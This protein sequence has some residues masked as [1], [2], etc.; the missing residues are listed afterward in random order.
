MQNVFELWG[1]KLKR[2]LFF[3]FYDK[4]GIVDTYI[5]YLL[6]DFSKSVDKIVIIING[7]CNAEGRKLLEKYSSDIF[8]RE[9]K[10]Y[11]AGAY[12]AAIFEYFGLERM[13]LYDEVIFMN[14]TFFGPFYPSQIIFN[15]M[16]KRD[17]DFW[18]ITRQEEADFGYG[19]IPQNIQSYFIAFRKR[20]VESHDFKEFWESMEIPKDFLD[21]CKKYENRLTVFFE[22][23]GYRHSVL[24]EDEILNSAEKNNYNHYW[25]LPYTLIKYHKMPFLKVKP[26]MSLDIDNTMQEEVGNAFEYVQSEFG[27]KKSWIMEHILRKHSIDR[28]I[29]S[30]N[31]FKI[32]STEKIIP[33]NLRPASVIVFIENAKTLYYWERIISS[34]VN[35][36]D[37]KIITNNW[38]IYE[39]I[40]GKKD[41]ASVCSLE[42]TASKYNAWSHD[43]DKI[44]DE[45][46]V[47]YLHDDMIE[48]SSENSAAYISYIMLY[49]ETMFSNPYYIT[50]ILNEFET[51]EQLGLL[52]SFPAKHAQYWAKESIGDIQAK[53]EEL[54]KAL[55]METIDPDQFKKIKVENGIWIRCSV[56][57]SLYGKFKENGLL[58]ESLF[59]WLAQFCQSEGYFSEYFTTQRWTEIGLKNSL[60]SDIF[61]KEQIVFGDNSKIN[62]YQ[63]YR[64]RIQMWGLYHK[65]WELCH[66]LQQYEKIFV[67]G[68]GINAKRIYKILKEEGIKISAF[69]VSAKGTNPEKI[70]NIPVCVL[71][72][73]SLNDESAVV[74]GLN[75]NN[76]RQVLPLLLGRISESNI[77]YP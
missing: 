58:S 20:L 28:L 50:R 59:I 18:G 33:V 11:D 70:D 1:D 62:N 23:K 67:Y 68:A 64:N 19:M 32:I 73:V 51:D 53:P 26:F 48:E 9:N 17:I 2:L 42:K 30:A 56:L 37:L 74:L 45:K 12:K 21:A 8:F 41:F 5:D 63:D 16:E 25:F 46:I 71:G 24:V 49:A 22:E 34:L 77:F 47:A 38:E 4:D 75:K 43:I 61:L 3:V 6:N 76:T 15:E 7:E 54:M 39:Q 27:Y 69:I 35:K 60:F 36:A 44:P 55:G 31:L 72:E 57:K 65:T 29:F 13:K 40:M 52:M 66:K 14:D 10:G